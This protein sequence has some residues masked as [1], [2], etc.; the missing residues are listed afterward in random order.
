[1]FLYNRS[2]SVWKISWEYHDSYIVLANPAERGLMEYVASVY[3]PCPKCFLVGV[4]KMIWTEICHTDFYEK[5]TWYILLASALYSLKKTCSSYFHG[6]WCICVR[7]TTPIVSRP[8]TWTDDSVCLTGVLQDQAPDLV[9]HRVRKR[10]SDCLRYMCDR[11]L[12]ED[13][14]SEGGL[15][16]VELASPWEIHDKRMYRRVVH[17]LW[18]SYFAK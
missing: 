5:K 16:V 2:Q 1:M 17:I 15:V 18:N 6:A 13:K 12:L 14:R 8:Q 10:F 7:A 11:A 3:S 4:K 9:H